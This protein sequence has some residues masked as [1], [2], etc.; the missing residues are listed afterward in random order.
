MSTAEMVSQ[1]G[2]TDQNPYIPETS[3]FLFPGR[4]PIEENEYKAIH[5]QHTTGAS[6]VIEDQNYQYRD[7]L[8]PERT[9]MSVADRNFLPG[10]QQTLGQR[11]APMNRMFEHPTAPSQMECSGIFRMNEVLSHF[12]STYKNFDLSGHMLT[13]ETSQYSGM[14]LETPILNIQNPQYS[15][16]NPIHLNISLEQNETFPVEISTCH[17]P[18]KNLPFGTSSLYSS[19]EENISEIN[20]PNN[21]SDAI[22]LPS[23]S[24]IIE[25]NQ[26]SRI[27]KINANEFKEGD[28]NSKTMQWTEFSYGIAENISVPSC[29]TQIEQYNFGSGGKSSNTDF[30]A[31]E[32]SDTVTCSSKKQKACDISTIN[33]AIESKLTY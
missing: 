22:L 25:K 32:Y 10:F 26:E 3:T 27:T 15:T 20:N 33:S 6:N 19:K 14:S 2:V 18:L 5:L 9:P 12:P 29:A 13:N 21:F 1:Y 23:T 7:D 31:W 4:Q 8:I 17:D 11:N 16:S 24:Q 30:R 28:S